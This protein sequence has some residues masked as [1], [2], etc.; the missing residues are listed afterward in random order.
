MDSYEVLQPL[1][2]NRKWLKIIGVFAFGY[3]ILYIV[4]I[5]GILWCWIPIWF[6]VLLFQTSSSL[7]KFE[8]AGDEDDAMLSV[9]KLALLFKIIAILLIVIFVLTLLV[10]IFAIFMVGFFPADF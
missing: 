9:E 5:V 8:L 6:G 2:N 10:F 3:G 1:I 4:S 7:E